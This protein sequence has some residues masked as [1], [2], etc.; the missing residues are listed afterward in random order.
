MIKSI[1]FNGKEGYI[2]DKIEEPGCPIRDYEYRKYR[3]S[4]FSD[5]EKELL[6]NYRK[7]LRYWQKNLKDKYKN[8]L[9]V[10]CLIGRKF[11]F[12]DGKINLIFGPN[13]CGKTTI[14]RAI[15]GNAGTVDGYAH[16][17]SPSDMKMYNFSDSEDEDVNMRKHLDDIMRNTAEIEWDG[18]PIYYDNFSNR[19]S[20]G[21]FGELCGSVL[22]ESA[23]GELSYHLTKN[24]TSNGQMSIYL[25]K[26]LLEIAK[27]HLCY[28][29][30]FSEHIN[31][32]GTY[33]LKGN[34]IWNK[35]YRM[36]L[37][38]YL[39]FEKSFEKSPGTFLFDEIDKSLDILN[40]YTLYTSVLP[41]FVKQ[42][43]VQVILISHS[44][45]V[46]MDKIRN[47]DMYNFISMDEDYTNECL[48]SLNELK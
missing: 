37:D 9:L 40:I 25:L 15:A 35:C 12:E 4:G 43:G 11:E 6:L 19:K 1:T 23:G 16:L 42:T 21:I 7:S 5:R 46:L 48:K 8:E 27:K 24:V 34:D 32:D 45:L 31:D 18:V 20:Y 30:I 13:A 38:Y 3:R 47:N 39:G 17:A 2:L 44:P 10:K 33:K 36:Q 22:G 41:E 26:K 29:D 28:A 14:L